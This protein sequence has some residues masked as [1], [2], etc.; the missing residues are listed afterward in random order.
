L[1]NEYRSKFN[2]PLIDENPG[3]VINNMTPATPPPNP[4]D[5]ANDL[6]FS[7]SNSSYKRKKVNNFIIFRQFYLFF[8][9]NELSCW[10]YFKINYY[11][12]R[13]YFG[14]NYFINIKFK[15]KETM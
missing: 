9:K 15:L 11:I 13:F 4:I 6:A 14:K 5:L 2:L 3:Q 12:S 7:N 1:K 8:L 10:I